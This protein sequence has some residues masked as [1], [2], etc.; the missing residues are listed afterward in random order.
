MAPYLARTG[1]ISAQDFHERVNHESGLLGVLETSADMRD[2][3]ASETEDVRA[4]EAVARFCYQAKKWIGSFA[5]ALGGLDALVFAGGIGENGP[6][7][8]P[9]FARD[10]VAW[11]SN[12]MSHAMRK[13]KG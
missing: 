12:W 2:W 10:W 1:Q 8:A 13:Q 9:A 3:L 5:A 6:P 11:A 7:F 4:A